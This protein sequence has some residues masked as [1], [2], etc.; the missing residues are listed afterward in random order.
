MTMRN[1]IFRAMSIEPMWDR[2]RG[3]PR[4]K[5][6]FEYI[7]CDG[8]TIIICTIA[9]MWNRLCGAPSGSPQVGKLI[10]ESIPHSLQRNA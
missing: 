7:S 3:H 10:S 4:E 8:R 9:Q 6:E 2:A 5:Y 1:R